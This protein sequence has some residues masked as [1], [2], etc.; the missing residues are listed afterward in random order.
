M[1]N[2]SLDKCVF[3]WNLD[4]W[5]LTRLFS[6]QIRIGFSEHFHCWQ[7]DTGC[8]D[9]GLP[10]LSSHWLA[11]VVRLVWSAWAALSVSL[12]LSAC[13][14]LQLP[15]RGRSRLLWDDRLYKC[16][17]S[18]FYCHSHIY[19]KRPV[20]VCLIRYWM[21]QAETTFYNSNKWTGV[22]SFWTC[23]YRITFHCLSRV[24]LNCHMVRSRV[25]V[26]AWLGSR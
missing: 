3:E 15:G 1:I 6:S 17:R 23:N 7:Q 8:Q 21:C 18:L 16:Y 25:T 13:D 26:T 24:C 5:N 2:I 9:W 10:A 12:P 14:H 19:L 4:A 11:L 20:F 22:N